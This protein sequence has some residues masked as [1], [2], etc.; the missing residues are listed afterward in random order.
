[1]SDFLAV[2]DGMRQSDWIAQS[3]VSRSQAFLLI[4]GLGI[5]TE[6][7]KVPG[8]RKPQPY[9]VH[10]DLNRLDAAA[11]KL[12]DGLPLKDLLAELGLNSPAPSQ[13]LVVQDRPKVL[14]WSHA[15]KLPGEPLKLAKQLKEAAELGLP[16]TNDEMAAVLGRAE[17]KPHLDGSSPRPGFTIHRQEHHGKPYWT[18]QCGTVSHSPG[19]RATNV[20]FQTQATAASLQWTK[21]VAA[22]L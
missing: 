1:M 18:V 4:K 17:M 22:N 8:V 2:L 9:I 16:L 12:R 3:G 19:L 10:Q 21:P 20:G 5:Q 13:A 7:R 11:R 6:L 15:Y 14:P